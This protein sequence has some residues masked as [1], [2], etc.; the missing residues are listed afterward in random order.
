MGAFVAL[1][2]NGDRTGRV[3]A[4]RLRAT[5]QRFGLSLDT[6]DRLFREADRDYNG[7]LDF[8]EFAALLS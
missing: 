4:E 8:R 6:V 1:G 5:M 7:N 3:S 2:G